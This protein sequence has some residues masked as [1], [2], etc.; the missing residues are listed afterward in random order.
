MTCLKRDD[1]ELTILSETI[2]KL[3]FWLEGHKTSVI[4]VAQ[5][6]ISVKKARSFWASMW[7]FDIL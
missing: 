1:I 2:K 6:T 3:Q 7:A 5:L 4:P